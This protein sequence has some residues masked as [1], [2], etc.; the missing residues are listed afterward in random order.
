MTF[1]SSQPMLFAETELPLTPSAAD[2]PAK[3][4]QSLA[5]ELALKVRDLVYGVSIGALLARLSPDGLSW[6]TSQTCLLSGWETYSETWPRSG[7]MRCGIVSQL[8]PLAPLTG[9][10][11]FGSLPTPAAKGGGYNQSASAQATVRPSLEMMARH[12]LWPTP[13]AFD[14]RNT[15]TPEMWFQRQARNP[16]MSRASRPT[17][18]SVAVQMWPTPS[19]K[20]N[21]NRKGASPTSGDGLATAVRKRW[22]TPVARDCPTIAG[23]KRPKNSRGTEPLTVIVGEM[24]QVTTGALNPMWVEWLMGFP[25]GWTDL[26]PSATP[27]SPKS[28]NSSEER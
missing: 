5:K 14:A 10:I 13:G 15:N 9:G 11:A 4:Y 24:E 26:E 18:L 23:A 28:S 12:N 25:L 22:P 8:A 20:G 6:R 27:S 3:T 7:M 1:D 19:V 17:A 16:N 21:Y 2:F